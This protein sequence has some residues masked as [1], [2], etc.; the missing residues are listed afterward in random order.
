MGLR[1]VINKTNIQGII[2]L[3]VVIFGMVA[4]VF[5]KTDAVTK[6][7]IGNFVVVV[8][9]YGE[10]QKFIKLGEHIGCTPDGLI[11]SDGG[12]ETKC[13]D[14]KTHLYYLENLTVENFKKECK[15]YYW[16][17]QG[18]MYITNKIDLL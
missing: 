1:E 8:Y 16:Q 3:F 12:T 10:N 11:E 7:L 17:I 18:S 5:T 13:P 2:A 15:D 4:M 6:S 14:S 9:N